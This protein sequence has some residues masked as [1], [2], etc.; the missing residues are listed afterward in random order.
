[1]ESHNQKVDLSWKV[2]TRTYGKARVQIYEHR[3]DMGADAAKHVV[4]LMQ[5]LL[6]KKKTIRMVFAAAPSQNEFLSY[7]TRSDLVDW[8]RVV[9]FHMDEYIGLPDGSEQ[10]FGLF[11]QRHLFSKVQ[12]QR[13]ELLDSRANDPAWE[14]VRYAAL[15]KQDPIDIVCLGIGENGHIAFNDPP[16]ANF[17]DEHLVKVIELDERDRQ[18]QV[19]DG[20]FPSV[21]DVPRKAYTLTIPALMSAAHL[22][23]VVPSVRKA[24]AVRDALLG[25]ITTEVPASIMREHPDTVIFLD[26]SSALHLE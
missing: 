11:L 7:L 17:H 2:R 1:M 26:Q 21:E 23:C 24:A 6:K 4:G 25:P 18:Q 5:G 9:G 20:C 14:C 13:V 16:V 15:L 12:M 8:S 22:S 10:S 19:N 3:D